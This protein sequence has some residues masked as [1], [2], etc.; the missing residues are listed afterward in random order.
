MNWGLALIGL[1]YGPGI[2]ALTLWAL[3]GR[4]VDLRFHVRYQVGIG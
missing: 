4:V 2:W 3:P 1:K